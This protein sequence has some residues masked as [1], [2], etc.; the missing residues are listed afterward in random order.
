MTAYD[1]AREMLGFRQRSYQSVFSEGAAGQLVLTD[2]AVFCRA[3]TGDID[4]LDHN[5]LMTMHG[6]R[7]V[8]FRIIEHLKLSPIEIE[9]VYRATLM[10]S[11]ARI[12]ASEG[13]TE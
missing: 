5:T 3:F 6:R 12:N 10:R 9:T 1:R 13:A 7:Q 8:F 4:G 2:L 11:A